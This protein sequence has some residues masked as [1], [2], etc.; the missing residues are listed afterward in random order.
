MGGEAIDVDDVG[1]ASRCLRLGQLVGEPVQ[2]LVQT[3]ALGRARRLDVPLK[4]TKNV[5]ATVNLI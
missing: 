1:E 4:R 3:V 5:K 2:A